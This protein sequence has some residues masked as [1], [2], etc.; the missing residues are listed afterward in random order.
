MK[1]VYVCSPLAGDINGNIEKAVHYCAYAA[2]QGVV[3]LAPHT[4]FTRFL[5]DTIPEQREQGLKMGIELLKHC[6][7][8]WC[9]GDKISV[10]MRNEIIYA[11]DHGIRIRY[12]P[13]AEIEREISPPASA[14]KIPLSTRLS[15][16][17]EETKGLERHSSLINQLQRG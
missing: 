10:G 16:A 9:C 1:L 15:S 17:R 6:D 14:E 2:Q 13:T 12:I 8:L 11:G 3:P 5:N 4:I 7:E